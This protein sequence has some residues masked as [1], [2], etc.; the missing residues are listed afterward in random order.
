M[1]RIG[2]VYLWLW[3]WFFSH[4]GSRILDTGPKN[5]KIEKGGNVLVVSPFFSHHK[6]CR[7]KNYF[8]FEQVQKKIERQR[9]RKYFLPKKLLPSSQNMGC[10]SGTRK[11]LNPDPVLRIRIRDGKKSDP[12]KT[13]RIRNTAPIPEAK[14]NRIPDPQFCCFLMLRWCVVCTF[15]LCVRKWWAST[16]T[17]KVISWPSSLSWKCSGSMKYWC[18]PDPDPAI[19]VIDLQTANKKLTKKKVFPVWRIRDVY[20]GSWFLPIPDPGS[21]IPDP[22]TVTKE[23]GEKNFLSYFFL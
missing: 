20:P 14:N 10:R 3:S 17:A 22:K 18:G 16:L 1:L 23:R 13:S 19:F 2:N 12:G 4:P 8:I 11:K 9:L 7:I 21:R 5:N 6:F 15:S